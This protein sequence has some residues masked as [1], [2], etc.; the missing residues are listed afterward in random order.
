[1]IYGD[2]LGERARLT[3]DKTALVDVF[4]GKRFCYSELERRAIQCARA[5]QDVLRLAKGDRVG[6]LAHNGVEYVEAFFAAAK[7]GIIL[8]P[9]GTRL[10][11]PELEFIVRDSGMKALI[12][13]EEFGETAQALEEIVS[14]DLWVSLGKPARAH[15]LDFQECLNTVHGT[16]PTNPP[17]DAEDVYCILYT[18]GT[19]GRPKGVMLPRRMIAWNAYNTAICWGLH[20]TDVAPIF[21]PMYHAGG[22]AV[23]LTP[24]FLAGGTIVLHRTFEPSE[25]WRAIEREKCTV[26]FGVPTIFKMLMEAPEFATADL[27]HVRWCISGGAPLPLYLIEAYERRGVAF[28]QGY[29]LTE[30]GV[31]CF[32]M[33]VEESRRKR[34]SIG[35]PMM[36]T[37]GRL[38]NARGG[39][40]PTGEVG[41]LHL[42]GPHVSKG[43]WNNPEATSAA[44]DPDGWFHTSDL[45]RCDDEGFFY[46]AGRLKDMIISGGVNVYPAEIECELLLCPGV[47]DAA[48]VAVPDEKWGEVG[49]AFVV[50]QGSGNLTAEA[51]VNRL[52]NRLAKFKIPRDFVFVE[53]LPRTPYGKVLKGELR[54]KYLQAQ[55][56]RTGG[57]S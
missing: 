35:K 55:G 37:E 18:S 41:E 20:E 52:T 46:I 21:T 10:T 47:R 11:V 24:L 39:E 26:V 9:L 27:S 53:D 3:P 38:V 14:L 50:R 33:T 42:R 23:F 28:K 8:I 34:G 7:T 19:T 13:G 22:L 29:G 40:V 6:I 56:G 15:H 12:Y 4:T 2:I 25:V 48:I 36:F 49:V 43:Y 17:C 57:R 51:L 44:L 16:L 32:S 54:E 1:M 30:V 31:N 45:A 5:W